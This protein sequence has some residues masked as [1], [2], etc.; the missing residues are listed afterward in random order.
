MHGQLLDIIKLLSIDRNR[1]FG[2]NVFAGI[3]SFFDVWVMIGMRRC[4]INH[5]NVWVGNQSIWICICFGN[6]FFKSE[7]LKH[8]GIDISDGVDATVF[9]V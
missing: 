3:Q 4:N 9:P 1:F 6:M 7:L 2:K 8:V 5:I